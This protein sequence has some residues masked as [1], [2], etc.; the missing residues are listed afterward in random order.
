MCRNKE[1]NGTGPV[2]EQRSGRKEPLVS[3]QRG[4]EHKLLHGPRET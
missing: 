3:C 1:R 4:Q 2:E